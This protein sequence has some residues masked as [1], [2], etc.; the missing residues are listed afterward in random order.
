MLQAAVCKLARW[1]IGRWHFAAWS[2]AHVGEALMFQVMLADADP[3]GTAAATPPGARAMAA[4]QTA[5][6]CA[7][8]RYAGNCSVGFEHSRAGDAALCIKP[9][10]Y[11]SSSV[12]GETE[13]VFDPSV[14]MLDWESRSVGI[15]V[16]G[17]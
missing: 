4:H 17:A 6:S 8:D 16:R 12:G 7:R 3:F 10:P 13:T 1:A 15:Y 2:E 9:D 11:S 14:A 5:A